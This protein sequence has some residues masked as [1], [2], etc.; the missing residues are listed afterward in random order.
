MN[1]HSIESPESLKIHVV[2]S[3]GFVSPELHSLL[4]N[5]RNFIDLPISAIVG[6]LVTEDDTIKRA[7]ICK[8]NAKRLKCDQ[9][10]ECCARILTPPTDMEPWEIS[11]QSEQIIDL[12]KTWFVLEEVPAWSFKTFGMVT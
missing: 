2:Y 6:V 8:I 7:F 3:K 4:D 9:P 11:E 10:Q 5:T 1:D 12:L